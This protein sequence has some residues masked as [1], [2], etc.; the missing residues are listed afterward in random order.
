M[1]SGAGH[2]AGLAG[3]DALVF[4]LVEAVAAL[5]L[6]GCAARDRLEEEGIAGDALLGAR[7]E[8]LLAPRHARLAL[9]IGGV[10]EEA[11]RADSQ[12]GAR[13]HDTEVAG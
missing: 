8:A 6:A 3:L 5:R 1:A 11:I 13:P 2:V 9:E 4:E 12:T 7:A 10:C